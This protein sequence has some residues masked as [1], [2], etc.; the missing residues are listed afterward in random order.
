MIRLMNP[1]NAFLRIETGPHVILVDPWL[2]PRI[3][4]GGWTQYPPLDPNPARHLVGGTHLLITHIHEDHFDLNTIRLLPRD[5]QVILPDIWPNHLM[6]QQLKAE[7]FTYIERL[8]PGQD[9]WGAPQALHIEAIPPM[10]AHGQELKDY[11]ASKHSTQAIDAGFIIQAEGQKL[12]LFGDN[13]PYDATA[14]PEPTRANMRDADVIAF[15]YNGAAN[16]YPLCY[17]FTLEEKRAIIE[18]RERMRPQAHLTCFR[19]LAPKALLPYSADFS[20]CGPMALKF[21]E[22]YQGCWHMSRAQ[23][24]AKYQHMAAI[25]TYPIYENDVLELGRNHRELLVKH[26]D[27]PLTL[28]EAAHGLYTESAPVERIYQRSTEAMESL[29]YCTLP[30][31]AN[32]LFSKMAELDLATDW[33][34]A[35]DVKQ[36][37]YEP[38]FYLDFNSKRVVLG[39]PTSQERV[40]HLTIDAHY[41]SALLLG[42][43]HWDNAQLSLQLAWRRTPN[44]YDSS[45]YQALNFFHLPRRRE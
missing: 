6:H 28:T 27:P 34:L 15:S 33:T 42:D 17:D 12:V 5:I 24:S 29:I 39:T 8:K 31:A 3:Y 1:T 20:A 13:T 43:Q 45:L 9:S 40:L 30:S 10:N 18:K 35:I 14:L 25:P 44:V 26:V 22:L 21:A 38:K 2:S 41:L 36:G 37:Q 11:R 19:E 4:D 16:D 23:A 32:H 7:G